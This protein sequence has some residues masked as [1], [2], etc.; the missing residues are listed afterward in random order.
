MAARAVALGGAEL[1]N[2]AWPA[3][4][5]RLALLLVMCLGAGA[6]FL[7]TDGHASRVAAGYDGAALV[8]L[9]R[10]MAAV[11]TL[12]AG[13]AAA[14]LFWRLALPATVGWFGAYTAACGAMAAGPVLI[15]GLVHVALG[16]ALLHGGLLAVI[17]LLWRDRAV[18]A[19]L[20]GLLRRRVERAAAR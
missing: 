15:W 2:V 17:V 8:R 19:G 11:K 20:E 10:F 9:M 1:V 3:W 18:G 12:M 5:A 7:G 16:A 14:A 13:C 6:A 4:A